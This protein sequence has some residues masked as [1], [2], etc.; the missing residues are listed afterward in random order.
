MGDPPLHHAA[1]NTREAPL[2]ILTDHGAD[3]D[4]PNEWSETPLHEAAGLTHFGPAQVL[5]ATNGDGE[6]PTQ[7]SM[8]ALLAEADTVNAHIRSYMGERRQAAVAPRRHR[9]GQGAGFCTA[10]KTSVLAG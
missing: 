2:R 1:S 5:L 9:T 3:V 8:G 7:M 4:R 6:T 10:K